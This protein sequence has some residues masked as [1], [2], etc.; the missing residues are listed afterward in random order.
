MKHLAGMKDRNGWRLH[1]L[2]FDGTWRASNEKID[3]Q[4]WRPEGYCLEDPATIGCLLYLLGGSRVE[5]KRIEGE[6][7]VSVDGGEPLVGESLGILLA[8]LC[9]DT[10]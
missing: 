4:K 10:L 7:S 5:L 9:A 3:A 2:N 6:W 1:Q 8:R